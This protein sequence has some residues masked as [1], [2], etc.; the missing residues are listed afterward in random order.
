MREW[1]TKLLLLPQ[2]I[3]GESEEARKGGKEGEEIAREWRGAE[4]DD[5]R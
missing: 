3:Y 1:R 4:E 2:E 5:G